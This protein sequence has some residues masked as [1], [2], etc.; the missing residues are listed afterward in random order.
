MARQYSNTTAF[1]IM[2]IFGLLLVLSCQLT[3]T[4]EPTGKK[5]VAGKPDVEIP[6]QKHLTNSLGMKFVHIKPGKFLMGSP[7]EEPDRFDNEVQ[8][9]VAITKPYYLGVYEV[10]Q[11]QWVKVMGKNPSWSSADGGGKDTVKG[12][13]T[14]NFPVESI[15]W[16]DAAAFCSKLSELA[17]EK[18]AGRVYRL[19]TEA[20]WEY[21]CRAGTKTAFYFGSDEKQLGDYT[22]HFANAGGKPHAVGQKKANAWGLYDMYGNVWEW[23]Q[24]WYGEYDTNQSVDPKGPKEGSNRVRRGGCWRLAPGYFR[25]AYRDW[26]DPSYRD[27]YLGFRLALVP[28]SAISSK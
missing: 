11:G 24:D 10:T 16:N 26:G 8:H 19:P 23:C 4:A 2:L 6:G 12:Q 14:S 18:K 17:E 27:D 25:S 1:G 21:A 7:K 15:S 5:E 28:P 22:W 20:E 13:D 3:A 9:E